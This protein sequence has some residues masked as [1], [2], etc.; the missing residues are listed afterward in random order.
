M[1]DPLNDS[2]VITGPRESFKA[3]RYSYRTS[4]EL[5]PKDLE[6]LGLDVNEPVEQPNS[7]L[8][9]ALLGVCVSVILYAVFV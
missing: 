8:S 3:P 6:D 7:W 2:F 9:W 5:D 4:M 1:I